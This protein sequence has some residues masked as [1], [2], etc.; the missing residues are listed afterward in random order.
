MEIDD[1]KDLFL[2]MRFHKLFQPEREFAH[3]EFE[4][5]NFDSCDFS[6]CRFSQCRFIDC[7]FSACNLSLAT[8]DGCRFSDLKFSQCKLLG[9]DW[10]RAHWPQRVFNSPLS[11]DRCTLNDSS[12]FGLVLDELAMTHCSASNMDL[13]QAS[14]KEAN[15]CGTDFSGS[16]FHDTDLREANLSEA[17]QY[18]I[19]LQHN[20]LKGAQF[21]RAEAV[22]LLEYLD[23]TLTD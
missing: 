12:V 20:H 3:K 4:D 7:D 19:D 10:T 15:F 23:I 22:R 1:A 11:F 8:F 9:I 2:S 17:Y 16:L 13:R 5:C 6:H 21:S 14:F 18:D